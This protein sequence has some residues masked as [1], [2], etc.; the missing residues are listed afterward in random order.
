MAS[1]LTQ[2]VRFVYGCR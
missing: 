2:V 1:I